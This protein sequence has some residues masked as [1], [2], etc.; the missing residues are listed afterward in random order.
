MYRR[1]VEAEERL[2]TFL[3]AL[4]PGERRVL[5]ERGTV[6]RFSRGTALGHAGQVGERVLILLTGHVKLT[7]VTGDGR[8]VLLA[9]RGPGDLIGEQSA[10]DGSPRSASIGARDAV[11]ALPAPPADFLASLPAPPPASLYVMRLLA[12]RLRD[13]DGKRVEFTEHDV[14]GRLAGR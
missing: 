4:D 5:H 14:V 10:I 8:D 13:A 9:I 3:D 7:R 12:A 2:G 6:R 1:P 11:E